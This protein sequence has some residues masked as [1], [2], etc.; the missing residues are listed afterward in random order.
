MRLGLGT[1]LK[2]IER[3]EAAGWL[4]PAGAA[5]IRTDLGERRSRLGLAAVL[6]TLAAVLIAFGAMSFVA[7]NWQ[8]MSKLARLSVI[9]G[10]LWTSLGA[11]AILTHK[12]LDKFAGAAMLSAVAIFGAG[13]MLISQMYHVDGNPADLFLLWGGGALVAGLLTRSNP[14]LAAALLLF[15]TW[16][17]SE[18]FGD[19]IHAGVHWGFLPAWAAVAGG[20]LMMR[21]RPALHLMGITATFW[22]LE[23]AFA[24]RFG[25]VRGDF[26]ALLAG[27][28]I[29]AASHRFR[30]Q[31]EPWPSVPGGLM[32]YGSIIA[33]AST[34]MMH[35]VHAGEAG[36]LVYGA[37]VLAGILAAL[38][39]NWRQGNREALWFAYVAFAIEI[40]TLYVVKIGTLLG[41][42]G[43]F[44]GAGLLVAG[45]AFAAYRLH[46]ETLDRPGART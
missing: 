16:S 1:T 9:A 14:A 34:Y 18:R 7:A 45:L 6:A 37:L 12:G 11:A 38:A 24:T 23:S 10:G 27:L 25:S 20:F 42:A 5:S 43:F 29:M 39:W 36:I 17:L 46:A 28:A 26:L 21:W 19:G 13:I 41:T 33:F 31:L 40:V 35:P 30:G 15:A 8:A 2:D 32:L 3:W 44:L 4:T 22:I